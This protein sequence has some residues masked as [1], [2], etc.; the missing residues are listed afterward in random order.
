MTAE[1]IDEPGCRVELERLGKLNDEFSQGG[2]S[3][4]DYWNYNETLHRVVMEYS[5]NDM[6]RRM[7]EQ[8]RTL[9]YHYHLQAATQSGSSRPVSISHACAQHHE[10][11][12]RIL[13]GDATG[14]ETSMRNHILDNGAGIIASMQEFGQPRPALLAV[15]ARRRSPAS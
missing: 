14:A 1:R 13:V 11:L 4:A 6:L 9:T 5:G 10:I 7:A 2:S 15:N 8:A 12:E 3:F